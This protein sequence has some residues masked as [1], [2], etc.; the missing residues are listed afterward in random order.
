M[1][2]YDN[3]WF[4]MQICICIIY[5]YTFLLADWLYCFYV[6]L[7]VFMCDRLQSMDNIRRECVRRFDSSNVTTCIRLSI[8][9]QFDEESITCVCDICYKLMFELRVHIHKSRL[10][11]LKWVV[12]SV[13]LLC[14]NFFIFYGKCVV[15]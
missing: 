4:Y 6:F 3:F 15:T 1:L 8:Q 11:A 2:L 5:I 10:Y 13:F 9:N 14:Q 7:C 12:F